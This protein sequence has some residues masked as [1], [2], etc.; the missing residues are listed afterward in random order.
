MSPPTVSCL[1]ITRNRR[2]FLRQSVK[3][4]LRQALHYAGDI[5]MVILD[6]SAE[7]NHDFKG[8]DGVRYHHEP[9]PARDL[10]RRLN[11]GASLCQGSIIV[12]W[13]DDDWHAPDRVVKQVVALDNGG[14]DL[15]L[16]SRFYWF[17]LLS[18]G[19]NF[20]PSWNVQESCGFGGSFAYRRSAW[21]RSPWRELP[22]SADNHF[23]RDVAAGGLVHNLRDESYFAYIRHGSNVSQP[24]VKGIDSSATVCARHLM[25]QDVHFYDELREIVAT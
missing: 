5:E 11:Q 22:Q 14:F 6:G 25:G 20:S 24:L 17:L 23:W 19:A 7:P 21:A 3:Y 16:T 10:G 13:D 8:F 18:G 12:Q 15:V 2:I 1:C 4:F 9:S